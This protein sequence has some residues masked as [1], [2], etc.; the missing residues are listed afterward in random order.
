MPVRDAV[1]RRE[2]TT[3]A[4]AQLTVGQYVTQAV[5]K[6]LDRLTKISPRGFDAERF[7]QVVITA[8]KATPQ[9]L[10][11]FDPKYPAGE[12]SVL[13]AALQA[14]E[15]GLD[16]NTPTQHCWLL[17]RRNGGHMECQLSIGYRGYIELA[18]RSDRVKTLFAEVVRDGDEFHYARGIDADEFRHVPNRDNPDGELLYAYAIVRF[19]NGGSNFAVLSKSQV[20]DRRAKSDSWKNERS[21][22][23]S[24]WT[25][26]AEAMWKKSAVRALVPYLPLAA[27]AARAVAA[28]ESSLTTSDDGDEIIP[29]GYTADE[30]DAIEAGATVGRETDSLGIPLKLDGGR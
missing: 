23:Y 20:E 17:P 3:S 4:P 7:A 10:E 25:T 22:P 21:R 18:N 30:P 26:S 1:A 27:A 16:P 2:D 13:L 6:Q 9:L 8:V 5:E 11:C 24:P 15:V 14:A 29:A 28:D 12:L 19:M